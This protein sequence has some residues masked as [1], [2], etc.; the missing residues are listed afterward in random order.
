[1][2]PQEF[3]EI[4]EKL[5]LSQEKLAHELGLTVCHINRLENGKRKIQKT[6]ELAM[7]FLETKN[8]VN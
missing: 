7:R 1:V 4:R 5:G 8:Q 2:T 6:T 3:K